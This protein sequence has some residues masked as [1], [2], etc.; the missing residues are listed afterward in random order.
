M[1]P[2]IAETFP[3][4]SP[5]PL[6]EGQ[7]EG[8]ET[9]RLDPSH[10]LARALDAD[11]ASANAAFETVRQQRGGLD[12]AVALAVLADD[13]GPVVEALDRARPETV[14]AVVRALVPVVFDAAAQGRMGPSARMPEVGA[15]WRTALVGQPDALAAQPARL[16]TALLHAARTIAETPGADVRRWAERFA[17]LPEPPTVEAL[18]DAGAVLAWREGLVRLRLAALG[19]C[20]RLYGPLALAALG[21]EDTEAH[22]AGLADALGRLG[23]DPWLRPDEAFRGRGRRALAVRTVCGGF[24]GFGGPFSC[25]P[26]VGTDGD[27]LVASDGAGRWRLVADVFGTAFHRLPASDAPAQRGLSGVEIGAAGRIRWGDRSATL[28]ALAGAVSAAAGDHTLAVVV[29]DSHHIA[30]IA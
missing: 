11:R 4:R 13:L 27:D 20:A 14:E 24:V 29:P 6:G 25:P 21:V 15:A 22:R 23:A 8:R 30:L 7:G 12:A 19:V 17:S 16:A 26:E 10:P 2:G 9:P 18:L 1:Q 3:T 5:L 28:D